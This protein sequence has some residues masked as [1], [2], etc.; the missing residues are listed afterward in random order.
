MK[1]I[2]E[3]CQNHN[4]DKNLMLEMVVKAAEAGAT[5]VKLQHIFAD[6]ISFR[7]EFENGGGLDPVFGH[8]WIDRAYD[9]EYRRLKDLEL[10][11]DAIRDFISVCRK[12]EVEPLTTCF[13]TQHIDELSSLGFR[14]IKI[15]SYDC[16]SPYLLKAIGDSFEH[17]Y[18]STG[19]TFDSEIQHAIEVLQSKFSLLHCVTMYPT[20]FDHLNLR[21]INWLRKFTDE[22]V[23]YS[24]HSKVSEV[25]VLPSLLAIQQGAT[26]IERHFTILEE[27][28]SRD[29][30]VS[31]A[32]DQLREL[33]NFYKA[34]KKE[35]GV[36]LK[37]Y[38]E[39]FDFE[40]ALGTGE[41]EM[42]K[43]E[44]SNRL[45]YRGRFASVKRENGIERHIY[46]WENY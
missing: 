37:Q 24:D 17:I 30:P 38:E 35:R 16:A 3:L 25:G 9:S 32:P 15:A 6:N 8:L 26:I 5:H 41:L 18:V 33:V 2:A 22:S 4:G 46:N 19:A 12:Y 1:I 45:Y 31:I 39:D 36:I 28:E 34:D 10:Q 14:E 43:E 11:P 7:P 29:G 42:S 27:D 23:G 13:C 21:R 44:Y 20:P 40:L